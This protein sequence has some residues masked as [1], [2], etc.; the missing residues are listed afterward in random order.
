MSNSRTKSFSA[1]IENTPPDALRAR[2]S[3]FLL[4]AEKVID[5]GGVVFGVKFDRDWNVI[6]G[7]TETKEGLEEFRRSKYV[8]A[9]VGESYREVKRFLKEG[10]KVLFTGLPCQIAGLNLFLKI[11]ISKH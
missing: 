4:I 7:Y 1:I 6:F 5:E 10:K 9:W 3:S 8:Q 2:I 11:T